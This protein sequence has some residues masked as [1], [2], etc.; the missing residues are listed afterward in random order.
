M[1]AQ[2]EAA[3]ECGELIGY[4]GLDEAIADDSEG[5]KKRFRR[6][7]RNADWAAIIKHLL[8]D[9]LTY[10]R[11][12]EMTG[13]PV[14][15]LKAIGCERQGNEIG[16]RSL[17]LLGIYTMNISHDVPLLGDYHDCVKTKDSD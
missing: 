2:I 12:S 13:F 5:N 10:A 14:N 4:A 9:G 16:D 1:T 3:L 7:N 8:N 17:M 15:T 11:L 6:P